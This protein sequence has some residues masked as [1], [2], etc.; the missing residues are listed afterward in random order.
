MKN[1]AKVSKNKKN[2]NL[3]KK[4][5]KSNPKQK[6]SQISKF[7][8][9]KTQVIDYFPRGSGPNNDF[10]TNLGIID[11]SKKKIIFNKKKKTR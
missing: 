3:N 8:K 6:K 2:P 10:T 4:G 5:T 1:Q 9:P 11:T 7:S